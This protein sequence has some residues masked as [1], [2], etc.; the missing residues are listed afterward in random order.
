[1]EAVQRQLEVLNKEAQALSTQLENAFQAW[2]Q[3]E[4]NEIL[5][6]RYNDLKHMYKAN[7]A[8][9]DTMRQALV[10]KLPGVHEM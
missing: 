7:M 8:R 9:L 2:L 3:N 5:K 6:T 10:D 4:D 1:M